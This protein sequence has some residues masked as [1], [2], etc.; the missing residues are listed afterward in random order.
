MRNYER[1]LFT[2]EYE[3]EQMNKITR[4]KKAQRERE[5]QAFLRKMH[6]TEE[7]YQELNKR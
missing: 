7:Q 4:D 1:A 2:E 3:T 6:M 5:H